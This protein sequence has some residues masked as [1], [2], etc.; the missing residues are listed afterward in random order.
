M[1]SVISMPSSEPKL[2]LADKATS[3]EELTD[4]LLGA[5]AAAGALEE[6]LLRLKRDMSARTKYCSLPT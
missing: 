5:A 1:T 6:E 3:D 4:R 2:L